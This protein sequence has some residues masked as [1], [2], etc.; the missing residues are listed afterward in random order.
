MRC[1][2]WN[3]PDS[4]SQEYSLNLEEGAPGQVSVVGYPVAFDAERQKWYCD[5]TVATGSPSYT[6]FIRLA[7][8]RYQPHALQN[9]KLSRVV[10]ADFAQ[11]T[12]DRAAVIMAD[13][14]HPRQLR[15]TV[16]GVVPQAPVPQTDPNVSALVTTPTKIEVTV[17]Q[18]DPTLNS[19]LAWQDVPQT[20]VTIA[21]I[22]PPGMD[23]SVLWTGSINFAQPPAENQFRLLIREYEY[24][25]AEYTNDEVINDHS[26]HHQPRR[27][28]YAESI[29]LDQALVGEPP[30]SAGTTTL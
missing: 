25:S 28:V 27:L 6:P 2:P 18:L 7:L 23:Q 10:L 30:V 19:D 15:V 4:V 24:V 9:A 11:L 5:L 14:Y 29:V 16:S 26:I 3:F 12:P 21:Q 17:Q 13:P 8:V 22:T 20:A 1:S